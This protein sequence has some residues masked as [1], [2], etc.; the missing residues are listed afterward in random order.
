LNLLEVCRLVDAAL[1]EDLGS[2]DVTTEFVV[3]PEAT[4]EGEIVS[5]AKGIVAGIPVAGLCFRRLDSRV[6]FEQLVEDGARVSRGQ[7]L[8]C[9]S[10]PAASILQAERVALNFIQRLSGIATLTAKFVEAV[11]GHPVKVLDTRKTTP[12]LRMLEK[13]AVRMGGGSNHRTGLYDGILIK[14]NHL[15]FQIPDEEQTVHAEPWVGAIAAAVSAAR[16][17]AGHLQR[18]EVEA[19]TLDQVNEAIRA[20]ADAILLDNM[21]IETLREAV[22]MAR[23][24]KKGVILEASGNVTLRNVA[25]IADTGVDAISIGALT[26]SS[27]ALDISLRLWPA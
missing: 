8:A 6:G 26:H 19:E 25:K 4:A 13:Y 9:V 2:G 21:D 14:D 7:V 3:R 20:G 18:V 27:P 24:S 15:Q 11:E 23:R 17:A 12:G 22:D 5:K 16:S 1:S 10:G